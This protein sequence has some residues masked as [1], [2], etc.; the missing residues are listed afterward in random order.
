MR[1]AYV[2]VFLV[3]AMLLFGCGGGQPA[4]SVPEQPGM[5]SQPAAETGPI[6]I[7][8]IGP[9]T[10]DAVSIGES[11]KA[12]VELAVADVNSAGGING[13]ELKVIYEDGTCGAE[14]AS[15]AGNKLINIDKVPVIIGGSCSSETLA[16]APLAEAA[17]VVLFSDCS[18]NPGVRDAGDYV[19]RDYPSDDYQGKFAG[20]FA[21]KDLGSRKVAIVSCLSEW[22]MGMRDKFKEEYTALGGQV[23]ADES[24]EVASSDL[25]TQLTK[26]KE[27]KP[28][29]LYFVAYTPATIPG[30]KQAKELGLAVTIMGGDVWDDPQ[31]YNETGQ[32]SE[33]IYF[34]KGYAP[35]TDAYKAAMTAKLGK[36][37][38][39]ICAPQAY[40]AVHIVADVM[41]KVGTDP[42]AIKNELYNVQGYQGVSGPISFDEKGDLK[43]AAMQV[44]VV[45]GGK[46]VPYAP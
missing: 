28:D 5:P 45:S 8:F 24:F 22:C 42:T 35:L 39:T 1:N 43:D 10:G 2:V 25:R 12:S 16:V 13:R 44:M 20:E 17:K 23:V 6:T 26:A 30:L 9:L 7:G 37:Q 21:Y 31:I 33:G 15:K 38:I 11:T 41:K 19:F 14:G 32:A 36:E 40:D 46:A 4:P 18:S 34:T 3:C 27:A 29:L